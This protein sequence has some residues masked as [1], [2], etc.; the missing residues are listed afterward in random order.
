M[1]D[2]ENN[3][4]LDNQLQENTDK[5]IA[6][7]ENQLQGENS[8]GNAQIIENQEKRQSKV[9]KKSEHEVIHKKDG[10]LH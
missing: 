10:R 9:D 3:N 1:N 2:E 7:E 4:N 6:V 8:P 5:E